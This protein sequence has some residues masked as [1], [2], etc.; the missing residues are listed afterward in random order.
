MNLP[1]HMS[2]FM[3]AEGVEADEIWAVRPGVF[4][5]KHKALERIA[6]KRGII[7]LDLR[8][9][10]VD[11]ANKMALVRAEMSRNGTNKAISFGEATPYN[12]KN[13]YPVAMAEK[14][15]V[16]R[17]ILKILH[18]HG[19]IYSESEVDATDPGD[20]GKGRLLRSNP[21][22]R[23]IMKL[24]QTGLR[25]TNDLGHLEEWQK[26]HKDQM[27]SLPQD[28]LQQLNE[29]IDERVEALRASGKTGYAREA[30]YERHRVQE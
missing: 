22:S 18:V 23:E 30:G 21:V 3:A 27:R 12:N 29:E 24:L 13:A 10:F 2:D 9:E 1:K 5:V 11:L 4:A 28:F 16:G 20:V 19:D 7:L 15:A 25:N 6:A 8:L 14:R 26:A 17:C